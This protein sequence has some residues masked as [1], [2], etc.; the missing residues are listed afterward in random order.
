MI[1]YISKIGIVDNELRAYRGHK[2][3][4]VL[5]V[6]DQRRPLI[7]NHSGADYYATR[8]FSDAFR[9]SMRRGKM[10]AWFLCLSLIAMCVKCILLFH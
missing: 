7:N 1:V 8:E 9:T 4:K 3:K 5:F 2:I 10:S 6:V